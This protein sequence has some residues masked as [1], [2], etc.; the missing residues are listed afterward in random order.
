MATAPLEHEDDVADEYTKPAFLRRVR[1]SGYKSI[2]YCDVEL[3]PF[4]IL[5]GRN[6]SGKSNFL[7]ALVFL[8]DA[9]A[10]DVAEAVKFHGGREGILCRTASKEVV[11]I[12]IPVPFHSS[13][14]DS[15]CNADYALQ[16]EFPTNGVP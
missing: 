5:V 9:S 12:A 10:R 3:Q 14:T 8:R 16:V 2:A 1:I 13:T 7:D 4:T 6:G 15:I 11:S